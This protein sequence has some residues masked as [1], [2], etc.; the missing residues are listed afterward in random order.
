[1]RTRGSSLEDVGMIEKGCIRSLSILIHGKYKYD[2]T[3]FFL[4]VQADTILKR[5]CNHLLLYIIS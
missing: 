1:M 3:C 2:Q 4:L 5:C